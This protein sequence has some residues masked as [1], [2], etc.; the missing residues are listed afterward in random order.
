MA[1]NEVDNI[2]DKII[3]YE[4]DTYGKNWFNNIVLC[5]GD[6][7]P[8]RNGNEGE[9]INDI[10]EGIMSDF[11]PTKLWTSDNTFK[12]RNLNKAVN[13]G[14][15]FVDYSGHGYNNRIGT[16]PP[17][18]NSWVMYYDLNLLGLFN[19]Y[20]L[21]IVYFDACLTSK[22]DYDTS[23]TSVHRPNTRA[24]NSFLIDQFLKTISKI[25]RILF[26]GN[27][28]EFVSKILDSYGAQYEPRVYPTLIPCFSW[29]WVAK[30]NGGAIATIG[31]TRTAYGGINNGAGKIAIEFFNGYEDSEYLGQMMTYSQIEY[32]IDVPNDFLTIEKFILLG[33][34]TLKV[35]GYEIQSKQH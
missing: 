33:D 5:G 21:P 11:T 26:D 31:A 20:K 12:A 22:L 13:S 25:L 34:P 18:D 17:N 2:V 15:G 32:I 4:T 30:K 27:K 10:V 3:H 6:T 19:G 14:A 35:G 23:E 29:E 24:I 8:F 9:I 7:F 28:P 1:E 16:H